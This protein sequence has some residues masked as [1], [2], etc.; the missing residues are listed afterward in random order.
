[1]RLLL[2]GP[3]EGNLE[4]FYSA[5]EKLKP[6]W[7]TCTGDFGIWVDPKLIE[8]NVKQYIKTEFAV[9]YLGL[10]KKPINIP[11]LTIAGAHDDNIWLSRRVASGNLDILNNVAYL[12]QGYKT[13]IGW[14]NNLR[15]T[16]LGK[17]YSAQTY[18][19]NPSPKAYRHYT[20]HEV[21][22][23]CSSGPT[24]LLII[25]EHIDSPG[26]RNIVFATRPKLILTPEFPRQKRYKSVQGIPIIS[27]ARGETKL[28]EWKDNSFNYL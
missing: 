4:E 24:D 19:G 21:E 26:L 9:Y 12:A 18:Q 25:Y 17:V 8:N 23:A 10:N 6:H 14:E 20:R 2:A 22:R 27:L 16:G 11:T 13:V 1:M 28:V 5:A 15:V 7:I 3:V